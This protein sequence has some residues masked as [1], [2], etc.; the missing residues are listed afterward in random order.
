M[1]FNIRNG[2][3]KR[4]SNRVEKY[5]FTVGILDDKDHR[6]A[7]PWIDG[8]PDLTTFAGGEISRTSRDK[9]GLTIG[10]VLIQNMERLGINL[11]SEPFKNEGSEIMKFMREFL[12]VIV[13]NNP[14]GLRRVEN[15]LQAVV[16]NP[17]LRKDYGDNT[18]TTAMA[19]GFDRHLIDT[20]QTFKAI[21]A[22]AKRV[23]R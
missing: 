16:R 2:F 19:K 5:N 1:N 13:K 12:K 8:K 10:E 6:Q 21:K 4:L 7:R 9:S 23:K 20:A 14:S 11:L 18:A 22:K 15:L 17:I 3:K